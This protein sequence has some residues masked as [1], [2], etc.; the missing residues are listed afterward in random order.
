MK[1]GYCAIFYLGCRG[2]VVV[3]RRAF[4]GN[5]SILQQP[6][7]RLPNAL[8]IVRSLTTHNLAPFVMERLRTFWSSRGRTWCYGPLRSCSTP[9]LRPQQFRRAFFM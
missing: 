3:R 1:G 6:Q 8:G 9:S 5:V 7:H 2:A 4:T